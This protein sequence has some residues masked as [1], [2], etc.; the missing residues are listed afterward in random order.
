M[1]KT[2]IIASGEKF[3]VTQLSKS[4]PIQLDRVIFANVPGINS[5]TDINVNGKMPATNQI[6]HTAPVTQTGLLNDRT[7]VYSIILDTNVGDFSFN[8]IGLVN[9][10]TNTLCMV[11]HTDLTKKTK[12]AGQRQGNTITESIWLEIDNA[13][14]STGVTVNAQTWQIDYSRRLAGEDERIRLTN[15]D[16][17]NRLVIMSGF[18]V[19]KNNN[20]LTVSPGLAYVSGLRVENKT[21]KTITV[22]NNQSLFIDAWLTGTVTGEWAV[23]YNIIAGT[24]LKDY[25]QSVQHYVERLASVDASGRLTTVKTKRYLTSDDLSSKIDSTDDDAAATSHAVKT[26]YDLAAGA[27]KKTGDTMTGQLIL[28]KNGLKISYDNK[29]IMALVTSDDNYSHVFYDAEKQKWLSKFIYNSTGNTWSFQYVDDVLINNKSVLKIGDYGIGSFV[30]APLNNP[31]DVLPGGCY[32]TRTTAFPE[33]TEYKNRNDSAS[34][35]V[36]PSTTKNWRVEMLTVVQG[37]FPRIFFRCATINGKQPLHE[38]VTT[39]NINNYIPVG[40]PLPWPTNQPPSGW[41]ECNGSTFDKNQFP[42]LAAAYPA[43]NLPDLRGEF[44]RGWDNRRGVDPNRGILSWQNDAIRN[45]YGEIS[46]IS[47]SFGASPIASG[48]FK[49]FEKHADHSPAHIDVGSVGGVTFDASRIVPTANDNR[50]R[51]VAFMYI[52]KAE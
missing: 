9:A 45:I 46:P 23:G 52:V 41:F 51:N 30:G 10:E 38:A 26:A 11:M 34:L 48:A 5:N 6:V 7:V 16:L 50:P 20:Q 36:F 3:F 47:E 43:G 24:D 31:D 33:L 22:A 35:V 25:S 4:Q 12:T 1:S 14:Q 42:K 27:V 8:Y 32:A 37:E 49:Y 29:N 21:Q 15:Y 17:Y 39:V 28:P 13:S 18:A 2:A 19:T 44:I 40:V